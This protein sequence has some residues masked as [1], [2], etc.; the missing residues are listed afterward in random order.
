M[1]TA[2]LGSFEKEIMQVFVC[3]AKDKKAHMNS[4]KSKGDKTT[5]DAPQIKKNKPSAIRE[6]SC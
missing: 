2:Y 5:Q 1:C 4:T 3:S 6:H